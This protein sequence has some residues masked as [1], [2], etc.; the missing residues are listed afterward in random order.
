MIETAFR[1]HE[2][3]DWTPVARDDVMRVIDDRVVLVAN[4]FAHGFASF[5]PEGSRVVLDLFAERW[6]ATHDLEKSF[7]HV[8]LEFPTR[9]LALAREDE[10][11]GGPSASLLAAVAQ[12]DFVDV[13]WIGPQHLV[14]VRD[15]V[16]AS[17][18]QPDTLVELGRAEGFDMTE[19]PH[20]HVLTR[21]M[22]IQDILPPQTARFAL[23]KGDRV[24]VASEAVDDVIGGKTAQEVLEKLPRDKFD[25]VI[26]VA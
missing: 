20:R 12:S 18:T 8:R 9:A 24:I 13:V 3:E 25:C 5:W 7:A 10:D 6:N 2:N 1:A 16:V 19:S 14:I 17:R 4:A 22:R 21:T 15:G 23:Q 26:F 11:L